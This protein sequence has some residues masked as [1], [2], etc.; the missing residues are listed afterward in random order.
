MRHRTDADNTYHDE[1]AR[2]L[3]KRGRSLAAEPDPI[4][5][6]LI[7]VW[8]AWHE[9]STSRTVGMAASGI[10]WVEMSRYCED[11]GI[12]GAMRLRWIR[13]MRRMDVAFIAEANKEAANGRPRSRR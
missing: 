6:D 4:F 5:P 11:M 2:W 12:V 1:M 3:A 9:L 10:P 8:N 13:L 7:P